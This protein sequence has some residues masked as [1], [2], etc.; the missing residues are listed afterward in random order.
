MLDV[1]VG[2]MAVE[3]ESALQYSIIFCC[4]AA[5]CSKPDGLSIDTGSLTLK[6]SMLITS[7]M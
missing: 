6:Y 2:D 1:D 7:L 4:C 5:G 3:A